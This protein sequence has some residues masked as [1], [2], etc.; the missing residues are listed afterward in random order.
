MAAKKRRQTL[1]PFS[2]SDSSSESPS[3]SDGQAEGSR[4][5]VSNQLVQG[6]DAD[7]SS[8]DLNKEYRKIRDRL[9]N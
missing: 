5:L 1:L 8:F 4:K 9:L 7:E 6:A 3:D 2:E